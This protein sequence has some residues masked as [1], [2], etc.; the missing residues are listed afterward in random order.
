MKKLSVG[1]AFVQRKDRI[2]G[3]LHFIRP[4]NETYLLNS[5]AKHLGVNHLQTWIPRQDTVGE[6]MNTFERTI[7]STKLP[8]ES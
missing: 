3:E 6:D 1:E 5:F 7:G 2:G 4:R 8:G